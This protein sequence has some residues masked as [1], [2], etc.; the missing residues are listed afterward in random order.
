MRR[1]TAAALATVALLAAAPAAEA[2]TTKEIIELARAGLG[3]EVLLALIDVEGGVYAI[4]PASIKSLKEA[5]VSERVIVAMVRSGRERPLPPE[6]QPVVE[7]PVEQAPQPQVIVIERSAP[8]VREVMVPV[9]VAVAP[10]HSRV[11]RGDVVGRGD[12]GV[13][14]PYEPA[15]FLPFQSAPPPVKPVAVEPKHPVYW[16]FGGKLRPDA[17]GQKPD[18]PAGTDSGKS[19]G[20][21][22]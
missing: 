21:K 2:L 14:S 18:R 4:D 8:E 13:R 9:Y 16:G 5:G 7:P 20:R 1:F 15:T 22:Q 10:F 12:V 3:E 19:D 17:W 11:R 6:P